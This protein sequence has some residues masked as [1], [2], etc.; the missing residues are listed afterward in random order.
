MKTISARVDQGEH[1]RLSDVLDREHY[2]EAHLPHAENIPW[3]S[4]QS[5]SPSGWS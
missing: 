4:R 3:T 5:W 1:F 2:R